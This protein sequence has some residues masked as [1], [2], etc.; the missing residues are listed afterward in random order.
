MSSAAAARLLHVKIIIKPFILSIHIINANNWVAKHV[1]I[2][3]DL[4]DFLLATQLSAI[5]AMIAILKK[6]CGIVET[7]L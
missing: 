6:H 7:R 2:L 4:I 1:I 5:I 3:V